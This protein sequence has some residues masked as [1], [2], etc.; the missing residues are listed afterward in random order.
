[1]PLSVLS[2]VLLARTQIIS[3]AGSPS[4]AL[5][6]F[7][8]HQHA[9]YRDGKHDPWPQC[10]EAITLSMQPEGGM[11]AVDKPPVDS[12]GSAKPFQTAGPRE[13]SLPTRPLA[14]RSKGRA[15]P[16]VPAACREGPG[17]TG[18]A[19]ARRGFSGATRWLAVYVTR[20]HR[21]VHTAPL[22]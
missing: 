15:Q 6:P 13:F 18:C 12:S 19:S 1:M 2:L 10:V 3:P 14:S 20:S 17:S 4:P 22:F 7:L 16:E 8:R 21:P 9:T 11:R 5:A